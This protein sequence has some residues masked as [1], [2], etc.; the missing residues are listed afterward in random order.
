MQKQNVAVIGA[1]GMAGQQ[2]IEALVDH[3]WFSVKDL[4]GFKSVHD[5]YGN[6]QKGHGGLNLP[7]EI[8]QMQ[9]LPVDHLKPEEYDCI[10]SAV[11]SA[12]AEKIEG[13]LARTTPVIST[14]SHFR[15]ESDV[16][17]FLPIVNGDH[18]ELLNVQ[19]KARG[20]KGF[21]CPG[22]NCTT[23]GLAIALSP[24]YHEFGLRSVI[25]T[26][27]Q[28]ISGAGYNGVAAY[29]IMGNVIPHI[30]QE[31]EKVQKEFLKIFSQVNAGNLVSPKIAVDAKCNRVPVLNGHLESV[32]FEVDQAADRDDII[33]VLEQFEGQTSGL[34]LPN[35]PKKP[36]V[37][38]D[39]D[40]PYHPQPRTDLTLPNSGMIT[41]VG[42][43]EPTV[44]ENGFKMTILSHN[45]ELG[46][47]RGGVLSAEYLLR[48]KYF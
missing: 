41:F 31:E 6:L 1:T 39:R 25:V 47:G 28:A 23:V 20:W 36:I 33:Q 24:I 34:D 45:T 38:F 4:F 14:A 12:A 19:R 21:V 16:P 9:V 42:G 22:P 10:F 32:F 18:A 43:L 35:A 2:F 40:Q 7:E 44:F 11:P 37:F 17:I 48:Q 5:T 13:Q 8:T 15:Y 46:A 26:S 30:P 29:D 3:P 27:M